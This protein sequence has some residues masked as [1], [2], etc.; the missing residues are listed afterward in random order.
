[1]PSTSRGP[2]S[3]TAFNTSIVQSGE[4]VTQNIVAE[5]MLHQQQKN[6]EKCRRYR[7]KCKRLKS[8]NESSSQA[9]QNTTA[10]ANNENCSTPVGVYCRRYRERLNERRTRAEV[11]PSST[12]TG[13][14][15]HNG[16]HNL[17]KNLFENNPFG[18]A[19]TFVIDYGSKMI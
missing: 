17:F 8:N 6:A 2:V 4:L 3:S 13:Y 10:D 15:R 16:S 9:P 11:D 18:F 7:Q 1:M 14:I 19:C 5:K 12:Y